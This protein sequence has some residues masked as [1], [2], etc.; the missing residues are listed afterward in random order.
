MCGRTAP[1]VL[2]LVALA[3]KALSSWQETVLLPLLERAA[4]GESIASDAQ[5]LLDDLKHRQRIESSAPGLK[6]FR[7]VEAPLPTV[8][9]GGKLK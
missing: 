2:S 6:K 3:P 1:P 8:K 5:R 4:R 9:A 7:R